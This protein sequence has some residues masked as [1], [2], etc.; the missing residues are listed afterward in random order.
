M[1]RSS[2]ACHQS[3]ARRWVMP[4]AFV[5]RLRREFPQHT[6]LEAWDRETIRRAAA[7]GRRRVH[8]VRRP[9]RL[10]VGDAAAL[11]AEP[12]RRRRQPD[13]SRAA[14][15]PR[16]HHQ[17]ARHPRAVDRRARARR[18]ASRSRA[19][20]RVAIRAQAAHRWA[21]DELEGAE[22]D[23]DAARPAHGH[24]RP[25]RDR[26]RGGAASPRRSACASRRSG[27]APAEPLPRRRRRGAGRPIDLP[28]AAGA[29][30]RASSSRAPHTPRDQRLIGAREARSR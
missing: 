26:P 15:Q 9:R 20:C 24:R 11:G 12:G 8:A 17:R 19:S 27:G 21:Q 13:V 28:R 10:R 25:R 22:R 1:N 16:R 3:S 23:P 18:H 14:R 29:E 30:R 7:R 2:I 6:F 4:R 5:D